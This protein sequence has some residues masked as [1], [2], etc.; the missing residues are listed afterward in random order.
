MSKL[1][2]LLVCLV[3]CAVGL[4]P[5]VFGQ[6]PTGIITGTVTDETGAVVPDASVSITHKTTGAVRKITTNAAGIFSAPALD[7]GEYEVRAEITGFRTTVRDATVTA[8]NTTT[9][10][11]ALRVGESKE[12]V[13]V[14]AAAAQINYESHT[15]AGNIA[16]ST[17]QDLPLNGR[18][19]L[20]LATLE[21]GVVMVPGSSS[22]YNGATFT[23]SIGGGISGRTL[24]AM[25]GTTTWDAIQGG[26]QMNF[27]Q[28]VIQ[29]FQLQSANYDLATGITSSGSINVVTRSGGNDFHGNGYF[30]F[31]DHNM[32]AYPGLA[33]Q[34]SN[35][36]PFFA[37]R[38]PGFWVSGPIIKNKLFFFFNYEYQNQVQ[39]I[40]VQHDLPVFAPLDNVYASPYV[41]ATNSTRLDY[42]I[43]DKHSLFFRFSHDGNHTF[44]LPGS[45][46]VQPSTW[47]NN[48]NWAQQSVLGVTSSLTPTMVN[49]FRVQ[50]QYWRNNNLTARPDQCVS[51]C[52]GS[53]LPAIL[54]VVGTTFNAG[55]Y[56]NAP[57][58]RHTRRYEIVDN[59]SWQRGTHRLR[60]GTDLER[61]H[62]PTSWDFCDPFCTVLLA[63]GV[64]TPATPVR[65]N[66]DFLNLPVLNQP[67]GIFSGIGIGN[68]SFPGPYNHDEENS[69]FRPR[70]YF[71]DTWKI[72]PN[73]TLDYGVAWEYETGLFNSDLTPPA[74]LTPL[75][76]ATY[77]PNSMHP[78]RPQKDEWQPVLGFA[79]SPGKSGKTVIRGGAG[80][81]WETNYIFERWRG[82]SVFGP[83]GNSRITLDS[84]ALTN[85]YSGLAI[86]VGA[87]LPVGVPTGMTL[88]QMLN[89]YNQQIGALS[90]KFGQSTQKSGPIGVTGLDVAKQAIELFPP[91]YVLGRSYQTSL[92]VQRDLGHDMVLTADWAR[93]QG[94]HFN[95]T[96]DLDINH[97]NWFV[98]G[99]TNPIIPVCTPAQ[100]YIP[101]QECVQ[102]PINEWTPEGRSVY[103][104]L[105]VKLQKRFSH[106]IQGQL[107]YAFQNLDTDY[108]NVAAN[109]YLMSYGPTLPRHNLNLAATSNLPWGFDLSLNMQMLSRSPF[110]A[111]TNGVDLSGTGVAS[112]TPLPGIQYGCLG[113]TCSKSDLAK[114]VANFNAKYAGTKAPNGAVIPQ[115]A[116]PSHYQLGDPTINQD[117][118]LTKNFVYKE[119]YKLAIFGEVFNAFNIANLRGYGVT[120][121]RLNANPAA[122]TYAFGQPTQRALQTFGSAGPRAFQV[123]GRFSF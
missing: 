68:P 27:S 6:V 54:T 38:N 94:A 28:E 40:T 116:L 10:D 20:Q 51:P 69:N 26:T 76:T 123:G 14:E 55:N 106:R 9:V 5:P 100:R 73:L 19:F 104:A 17:I 90:Q 46:A 87:P 41:L 120:L 30:F 103:E 77:G 81:Y 70:I 37:R 12:V 96:N 98:N 36:N 21:P 102:G 83:L 47:V 97:T 64:I 39:A 11:M 4:N 71:S 99:V 48:I 49:D 93:R 112:S 118:R 53:G 50:Y 24:I 3:L 44:G 32:A 121:D 42:R 18:G 29:E 23:I 58:S 31:R 117:F 115:Y 85:I 107:S 7:A 105:L 13:N 25:D 65:T 8:G 35:P 56:F 88:G 34:V 67:A 57:Q 113:V 60:F 78:T 61:F 108:S 45:N 2:I 122:Q 66:A 79:W 114:A 119:R 84:T 22:Q 43:S 62:G 95:L 33:R 15:V 91:N 109:N 92:G 86:P 59:L 52:I 16:R 74:F 75:Y 63:P 89:I 1:T 82:E 110:T 101:G 111:T 72:K 80:L